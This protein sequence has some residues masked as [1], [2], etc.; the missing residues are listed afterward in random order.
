[1]RLVYGAP[2]F[3]E[4]LMIKICIITSAHPPFDIRI[5]YK[6]AKSLVR[7]GYDLTLIA[8]Y[9]REEIVDGIRIIN[10][11]RPRNRIERMTNTVWSAFRKALE[12]DADIY[13]FHDP[14]LIPLGMLLKML[15][16]K[17]IYDVH[18]DVPRQTL[19][20]HYLPWII[21][22]PI[23][24][25]ISVLE[26]FGAKVFNA[27]IPA[28]PKIAERFPTHKTVVVQ[29]FPI[30]AEL[31]TFQTIPYDQRAL[32]F[33]YVG[34]I[35]TIRGA[36]EMIHA[37]EFLNGISG[38]R[39]ELAGEFSPSSLEDELRALPMW[40][41]VNYHGQVSRARV[42]QIIGGVRAGLVLFHPL[43]NHIDAQPNKMFEYMSAGLPI[44][45]SD[46]PLWRR[47]VNSVGCGLLV[48]PL[49][50]R[51]VAEAMRWILDHPAEAEVMGQRGR[52]AVE[53]IYNWGVESVKL[54][55]LYKKLS[56]TPT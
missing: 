17:V 26:W 45:V 20:K 47:I 36:V 38:V 29:N 54:I 50:P 39:L 52:K 42:S 7:A 27:V 22:K 43:P 1:L 44:I 5:F 16:H 35:S 41:L 12:V 8:Q 13:H 53:Q 46:F 21:R 30:V 37:F 34:D 24:W 31:I 19:N 51:A 40:A 6:E 25:A 33:T 56:D 15:G 49:N 10:L 18:E 3:I 32:S 55:E 14:D 2:H 9:D 4:K 28:T 48:D 23:A 11:Q